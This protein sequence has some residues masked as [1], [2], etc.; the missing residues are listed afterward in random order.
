MSPQTLS[1]PPAPDTRPADFWN[2]VE[3]AYLPPSELRLPDSLRL[4]RDSAETIDPITYEVVRHGLWNANGEHGRVIENLAVS[5][6]AVEI[7]DF[8]TCILTEDAQ[9]LY[10]GPYLQYMAG[11][12]DLMVKYVME[13]RGDRLRDGDMWLCN[14]PIIGTAHQ[15]DVCLMCPVFL[16]DELFCWVANVVHQNDIGGIVPGSFCPNA[17]DIFSDPPCFPPIRIVR[18]GRI[19]GDLEA[20]YRRASRTPVNLSLDLRATVAGNLAARRRVLALIAQYGAPVVKGTMRRVMDASE[21]AFEHVLDTIPDGVYSERLIQEVAV[22]GDRGTYPVQVNARKEGPHV[23]FDNAGTHEQFGAINVGFAGWRGA[24]L[25]AINVLLLADQLGCIAGALRHVEFAPEP[26]TL[27][28]PDWGAAVS[29]AGL[30]ATHVG[31]SLGNAVVAK[32]MLASS[33]EAVRDR[34]LSTEMSQWNCHFTSGT[35][36]RGDFYVGGQGDTMLGATG[37]TW[38]RDGE[39]A[40]GQHWIPDGRGPNVEMYERDWPILYLFRRE[41]PG[42]AGAG[43]FRAGNGG[44]LAY[45]LH[46]GE[47]SLDLYGN[48]GIPKTNGLLGGGPGAT[49]TG[50]AVRGSDVREHMARGYVPQSLD[51]LSGD[52]PPLA[53]KGEGFPLSED[54]VLYWNWSP[55]GGYGDPLTRDVERLDTDLRDG[56]VTAEVARQVYGAVLDSDGGLD[57][58]ATRAR[59]EQL[60]RESIGRA[61]LVPAVNL[62]A[63][64]ETIGDVFWVDR[65]A[66]CLRCHGCGTP[67]GA[68]S[69]N[70]KEGMVVQERPIPSLA[71][72]MQPVEH[73]VDDAVVWRDFLC[74]GCGVRLATEVAYPGAEPFQELSLR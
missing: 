48:E 68:L 61:S 22:T 51:E 65:D 66:G 14:D 33:E 55:P 71:P 35:N 53:G 62:P 37:A 52:R 6:I 63:G 21:R 9:L 20:L 4:N 18:D 13:H 34:A 45:V 17:E 28:C 10:F 56:A 42:S 1:A 47:A 3:H 32:M 5:P 39:F 41:H 29:A 73:F 57:R 70:A 40:N 72:G 49:I 8:Q 7:R 50:F 24:I 67:T 27:T 43:R 16:G 11:Q 2:G 59:R 23:T 38:R 69:A 30:Y 25:G 19:D 44:E 74:S 36:Q 12:L 15:P 54:D 31:V 26:G 64:A 58:D 60:R 46:R